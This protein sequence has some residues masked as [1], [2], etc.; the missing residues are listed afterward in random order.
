MIAGC[1]PVQRHERGG[2]GGRADVHRRAFPRPAACAIL[3]PMS[4]AHPTLRPPAWPQ[5]R[6]LAGLLAGVILVCL[7]SAAPAE[8]RARLAGSAGVALGGFD[9]V[10]YFTDGQA[11][12]GEAG[13]ALR[14]RGVRWHFATP[15]HRAAFEANPQAYLP[16][17]DG[18]CA[19]SVAQGRPEPGNPEHW[20]IVDGRLYFAADAAHLEQVLG[21][22]GSLLQSARHSWTRAVGGED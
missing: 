4:C 8:Q 6:V 15:A 11:V 21:N 20:A 22:P 9:P 18:L 10:A 17:F 7:G 19:V 5:V 3:P 1:A 16:Q 14:W 2:G 12:A 13:I